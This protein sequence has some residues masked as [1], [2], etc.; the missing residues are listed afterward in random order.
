LVI[1][2]QASPIP[3]YSESRGARILRMHYLSQIVV[4]GKNRVREA[5]FRKEAKKGQ[6]EKRQGDSE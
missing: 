2:L 5:A 4:K 1:E 6:R 3:Q